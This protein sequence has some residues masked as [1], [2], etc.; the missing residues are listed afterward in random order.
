MLLFLEKPIFQNRRMFSELKLLILIL[1]TEGLSSVIKRLWLKMSTPSYQKWLRETTHRSSDKTVEGTANIEINECCISILLTVSTSDHAELLRSVESVLAQKHARWQLCLTIEASTSKLI[2]SVAKRYAQADERIVV[3]DDEGL[4]TLYRRSHANA[5]GEF[6]TLLQSGDTLAP[7]ALYEV[8]KHLQT[9]SQADFIYTDE[10]QITPTGR[11]QNPFF[12]PDWSPDYFQSC[13]YTGR[14]SVYRTSLV[15]EVGGF[16]SAYGAAQNEDLALRLIE[17][18]NRIYHIPKVL[19]HRYV[20]SSPSDVQFRPYDYKVAQSALQKALDCS[21]YPGTVEPYP[22]KPGFWRVHRNIQK[23]SL[24]SIIIPSAGT[25]LK[26]RRQQVCLLV[27]CVNSVRRL[28]TYRNVEIVVVDGYDISKSVLAAIQGSDLRVVRCDRPFN[29]SQR[30]NLGVQAAS[31][32]SLLLLNDDTEV[33][34]PDWIEAMLSLAQQPAVGVVGAKL[35]YPNGRLQHAGILMLAGNPSHA[36]FNASGRDDGYYGSNIVDRNYLA[37]TGACMMMRRSVFEEL[38]G[39][40]EQLP[41][42]YNDVDFCLRAH[43]LGYRNVFT[44]H[45]QLI[46]YESVSRATGLNAGELERLYEKFNSAGYLTRDP[47]YHPSLST[48]RPFFQLA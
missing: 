32:E 8:A 19:Y 26:V 2:C 5:Q 1:A 34:T 23:N 21:A 6:I 38:G 24:V 47:Y 15:R 18:T 3:C 33:I 46:H 40:D 22:N 35:L 17:R 14:L 7:N 29:F 20:P 48:R 25:S 4:A 37:V 45:A 39:F 30:I 44:P 13:L 42:N 9:H 16:R 43:Q 12:K 10:D 31:G 28:S 11:R 36:F 41:L 27:Q